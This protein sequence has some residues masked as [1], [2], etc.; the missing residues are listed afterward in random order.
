MSM[1]KRLIA[2]L[3]PHRSATAWRG[4]ITR[5]PAE[6][7][8]TA[9]AR[10]QPL[11][12]TPVTTIVSTPFAVSCAASGVPK[13]HDAYFLTSSVSSGRRPRRGSISTQRVPSTSTRWPGIL[14]G[15]TPASTRSASYETVEKTIGT[16]ATRATSSSRTISATAGLTSAPSGERSSVKPHDMSTTSRAGRSPK[17]VRPPRPCSRTERQNA[18]ISRSTTRS[19]VIRSA[20]QPRQHSASGCRRAGQGPP[21]QLRSRAWTLRRHEPAPASAGAR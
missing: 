1:S 9:V 7:P 13:K 3:G 19:S 8:S 16:P 10:T 4:T 15:Q 20:P 12:V 11:V 6:H 18:S 21:L 5:K 2:W 17:P 14:R